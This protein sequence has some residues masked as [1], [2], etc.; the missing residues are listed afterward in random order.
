MDKDFS[1][2]MSEFIIEEVEWLEGDGIRPIAKLK[3]QQG[4]K[5]NIICLFPPFIPNKEIK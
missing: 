4:N 2:L 1:D 3:D 5:S